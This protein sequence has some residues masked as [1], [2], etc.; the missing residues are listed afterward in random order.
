[1][2]APR[3]LNPLMALLI[4]FWVSIAAIG[5]NSPSS[6]DAAQ[7]NNPLANIKAFNIQDYFVPTLSGGVEG[8]AN[9]FWLRF[10]QPLGR[11]LL[12]AS[13]GKM[14]GTNP[15]TVQRDECLNLNRRRRTSW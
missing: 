2:T 11:V 15:T 8:G 13:V 5:Q 14:E 1:M 12:R 3:N 9:T 6:H 4:L 7:A 10:A